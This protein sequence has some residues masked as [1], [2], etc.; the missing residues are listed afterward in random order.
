MSFHSKNCL[1][2]R[3]ELIILNKYF[4]VLIIFNLYKSPVLYFVKRFID[5]VKHQFGS[6]F[7]CTKMLL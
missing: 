1:L 4:G 3:K 6:A 5:V 2:D 7:P